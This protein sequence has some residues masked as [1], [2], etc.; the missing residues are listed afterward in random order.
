MYINLL[1]SYSLCQHHRRE[2]SPPSQLHAGQA[3]R[4]VLQDACSRILTESSSQRP[5]RC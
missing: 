4:H 5:S 2:D 1:Q 3:S